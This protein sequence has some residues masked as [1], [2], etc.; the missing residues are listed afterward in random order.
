ME[1]SLCKRVASE[2]PVRGRLWCTTKY[3]VNSQVYRRK[4]LNPVDKPPSECEFAEKLQAA[5]SSVREALR[6]LE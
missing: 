6:M 1:V 4:K 3:C 5:A 2:V